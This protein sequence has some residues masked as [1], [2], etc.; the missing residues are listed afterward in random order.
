MARTLAADALKR[1]NMKSGDEYLMVV[2]NEERI[3][4]QGMEASVSE[5]RIGW[6]SRPDEVHFLVRIHVLDT[7]N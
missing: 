2:V 6:V 1:D 4:E 5:R 3:G 7:L